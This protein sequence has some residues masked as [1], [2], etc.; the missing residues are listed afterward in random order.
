M[1]VHT[2]TQY[3]LNQ[4]G[5]ALDDRDFVL[6][7]GRRYQ[8]GSGLF[9]ALGGLFKTIIPLLKSG[10]KAVGKEALKVGTSV[11]TDVAST[12]RSPKESLRSRL[13]EAGSNLKR[14]ADEKIDLMLGSGMRRLRGIKRTRTSRPKQSR[15]VRRRRKVQDVFS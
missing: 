13:K 4:A 14:K 8:R 9:S 10:A 1:E 15:P 5:G 12:G 6:F 3:Y 7:R 11:L 2:V